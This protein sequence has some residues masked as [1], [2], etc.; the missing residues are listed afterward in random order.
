MQNPKTSIAGWIAVVGA[1]ATGVAAVLS[2][3]FTM[4]I[5]QNIVVALAGVGLINASDGSQ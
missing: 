1:V 3:G 4:D 2:H 5:V